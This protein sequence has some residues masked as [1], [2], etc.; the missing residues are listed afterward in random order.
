MSRRSVPQVP[1]DARDRLHS[2]LFAI[3]Q[4]W[5]LLKAGGPIALG[6]QRFQREAERL[7]DNLYAVV[8]DELERY[9]PQGGA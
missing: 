5:V 4:R 6:E 9:T 8:E 3:A 2:D 1:I 7:T